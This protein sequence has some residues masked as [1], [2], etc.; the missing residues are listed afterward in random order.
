MTGDSTITD[1]DILLAAELALP[2]RMKKQ[3]FQESVLNPDQLQANMRQARADAEESMSEE[4]ADMDAEGKRRGVGKKSIEGDESDHSDSA[5]VGEGGAI[6]PDASPQN[7][8][9]PG[10]KKGARKAVEIGDTFE[11]KKLRH[12][13]RQD[14]AG[15]RGQAV[16]HAH[17]AQ[18][19][20]LYQGQTG[21]GATG[22]CGLRRHASRRSS[23]IRSADA[24]KTT[25]TWR[26]SFAAAT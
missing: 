7:S 20:T 16:V 22:R 2:H 14:D 8:S 10:D 13:T 23:A 18:A 12:A 3:P 15:A 5:E 4:G 24:Q 6:Q 9:S 17:R 25:T 19:R 1:R 26:C 21:Q 11:A